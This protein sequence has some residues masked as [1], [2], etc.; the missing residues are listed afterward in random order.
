MFGL[1]NKV[2]GLMNLG[3]KMENKDLMEAVVGASILVASADG[4]ISDQET[5]MAQ[6]ILRNHDKLRHFGGEIDATAQRYAALVQSSGRMGKIQIMREIE[7]IRGRNNGQ[8]AEDVFVTAISIAEADGKVEEKE[9]Q[10][11]REI[12]QKLGLSLT[13]Y[14]L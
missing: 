4:N 3:R 8:D 10:V 6:N 13:N 5:T 1:K 7:Q 14:G 2:Q 11:L 9:L 12:G